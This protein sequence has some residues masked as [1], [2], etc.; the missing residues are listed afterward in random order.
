MM[1]AGTPATV[2]PS[3]TDLVTTLPAA[4][5]CKGTVTV[6]AKAGTRTLA[7]KPA[8]L[9]LTDGVCQYTAKLTISSSQRKTART[10]TITAAFAGN[11]SLLAATSKTATAKLA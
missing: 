5:T 8:T 10:A 1:R 2:T 4:T 6:T 11:D 7:T 9:K 3:G